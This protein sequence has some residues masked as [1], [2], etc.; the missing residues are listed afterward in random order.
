MNNN[1]QEKAVIKKNVGDLE[2]LLSLPFTII[3]ECDDIL[4]QH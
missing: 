1:D 2:E 4:I 3:F